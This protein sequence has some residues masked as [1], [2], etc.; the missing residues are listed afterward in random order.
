M[1][2]LCALAFVVF[3]TILLTVLISPNRHSIWA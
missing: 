2:L 3:R 1:A